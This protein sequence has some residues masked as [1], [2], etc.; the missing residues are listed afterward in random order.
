MFKNKKI[1]AIIPAR[2]GSKRI[3]GKN[4]KLIAGTPLIA[5]IIKAAQKSKLIDRLIISTDSPSIAKV[6]KK[7]KAQVPFARPADLATDNATTDDVIKHAV[8]YLEKNE[9]YQPDVIVILQATSP[10]T[11]ANDI[12]KA[13]KQ[14]ITSNASTCVSVCS[15]AE[16]PEWM[17]SLKNNKLVYFIKTKTK[18]EK[19]SLYRLTGAIYVVKKGYLIKTGKIMDKNNTSFI[20]T[21]RERSVDIDE[22]I[23]FNIAEMLLRKK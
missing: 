18:K 12:D 8:L 6:A 9:N 23:D 14:L 4:T 16:Q 22:M 13:I 7:Y 3:P 15:V 17:Y 5:W 2:G 20:E 19:E 1:L 11:I 21:P 10:L